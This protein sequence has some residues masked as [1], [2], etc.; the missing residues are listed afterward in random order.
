MTDNYYSP[1]DQQGEN[2]ACPPGVACLLSW[3][4]GPL[5]VAG[6]YAGIEITYCPTFGDLFVV[7]SLFFSAAHRRGH[8][9]AVSA[10]LGISR[11]VS[12]L[13]TSENFPTIASRHLT[14]PPPGN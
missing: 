1:R 7:R 11:T 4:A 13:L 14:S 8:C 6:H 3:S 10:V 9:E 5:H 12:F 2:Q